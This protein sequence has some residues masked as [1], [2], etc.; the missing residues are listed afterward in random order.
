MRPFK[1][2]TTDCIGTAAP[3]DHAIAWLF[4]ILRV[5]ACPYCER[6]YLLSEVTFR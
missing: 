5:W 4:G 3:T 1:C 2:S 6:T